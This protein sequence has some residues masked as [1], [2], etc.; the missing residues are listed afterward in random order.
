MARTPTS[1]HTENRLTRALDIV[2]SLGA[3]ILLSPLLLITA[4]LILVCD[5][6]P[7]LFRQTRVGRK[8]SPFRILKFR[9]MRGGS[10]GCAIT[11]LYDSRITRIGGWLRKHKIDEL[12][13]LWN[14]LRGDMSLIGPRPEVPEFVEFSDTQWRDVLEVR[15]GVTDL[16]SLAFR[17]EES[18]FSPVADP[19]VYYRSVILPQKLHLNLRYQRS[20]SFLRDLKLLWMTARYSFF[21]R[22]FDRDRIL[23]S[24]GAQ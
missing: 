15:P 8:G 1:G 20:R 23:R 11:A 21:P 22:G 5:G 17:N 24:L 7:V 18:L 14:V 12:P 3:L 13:Q 2:G 19:E 10:P 9:T 4:I 16:A 6:R